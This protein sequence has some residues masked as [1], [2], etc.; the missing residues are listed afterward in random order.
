MIHTKYFLHNILH[1]Q[2]KPIVSESLPDELLFRDLAIA[3][4]VAFIESGFRHKLVRVKVGILGLKEGV[5][6]LDKL[7]HLVLGGV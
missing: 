5:H 4:R 1:F 3:I 7:H 6:G 2:I